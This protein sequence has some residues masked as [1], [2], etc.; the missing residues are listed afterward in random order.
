MTR[1]RGGVPQ[2]ARDSASVLTVRLFRTRAYSLAILHIDS[3][4]G[5]SQSTLSIYAACARGVL[6]PSPSPSP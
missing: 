2:S 4:S 5:S 6:T 3:S 1:A